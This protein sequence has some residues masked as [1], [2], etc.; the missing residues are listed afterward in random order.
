MV[1]T[2]V[3][4]IHTFCRARRNDERYM[5]RWQ[6]HQQRYEGR[7]DLSLTLSPETPKREGDNKMVGRDITPPV[8]NHQPQTKRVREEA[9]AKEVKRKI[10]EPRPPA[11]G[12]PRPNV[13]RNA[14]GNVRDWKP[15]PEREQRERRENPQTKKKQTTTKW[16]EDR[17]RRMERMIPRED[18]QEL[19]RK[20]IL[21]T[22]EALE[23]HMS[24]PIKLQR[25]CEE[26]FNNMRNSAKQPESNL[27]NG[28]DCG[29]P[30]DNWPV[31]FQPRPVKHNKVLMGTSN[32]L[33]IG[34][35][36]NDVLVLA[37]QL[38]REFIER[39]PSWYT[40]NF[41]ML[42]LLHQEAEAQERRE[43]SA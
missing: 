6:R 30:Q 11:R 35:D 39:T 42:E 18:Y 32:A 37:H 16:D 3:R 22:P 14:Y 34:Y 28:G 23:P 7:I 20:S 12:A 38:Y 29:R 17:E 43:F 25:L 2:M 19:R 31:G 15:T 8:R 13:G 36:S 33:P 41:T 5:R 21:T 1:Q 9:N 10:E 24:R 27:E 4:I 40:A 26:Y